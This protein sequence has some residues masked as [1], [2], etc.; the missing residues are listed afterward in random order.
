MQV[1]PAH[2]KYLHNNI[3]D[4]F[5]LFAGYY[6]GYLLHAKCIPFVSYKK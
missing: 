6:P 2:E 1:V 5:V 3:L 4:N